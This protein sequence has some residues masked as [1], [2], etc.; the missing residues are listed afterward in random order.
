MPWNRHLGRWIVP[1]NSVSS[2]QNYTM[3]ESSTTGSFAELPDVKHEV[4][5]ELVNGL[6]LT[7][8]PGPVAAPSIFAPVDSACPLCRPPC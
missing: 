3:P 5:H 1:P 4:V 6:L 2:K 8:R 7:Y